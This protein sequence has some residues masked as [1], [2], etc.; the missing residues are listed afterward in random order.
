M[1]SATK[2]TATALSNPMACVFL[3]A[4]RLKSECMRS[5][6]DM[7]RFTDIC[8]LEEKFSM[9]LDEQPMII[10]SAGSTITVI[11]SR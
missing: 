8:S 5:R 10:R 3:L 11:C 9:K 6:D 1:D 2:E 7:I 4:G